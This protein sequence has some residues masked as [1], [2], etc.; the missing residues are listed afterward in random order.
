MRRVGSTSGLR[1]LLIAG[2]EPSWQRWRIPGRACDFELDLKAGRPVV[3]S[4]A[5]LLAALMRAGLPHREFALGGQ[6]HGGAFVLDE[7]DRLV[8][9]DEPGRPGREG[10]A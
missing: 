4:S 10:A 2:H 1:E 7:H 6:H 9:L 8:E 5:Q 3:V